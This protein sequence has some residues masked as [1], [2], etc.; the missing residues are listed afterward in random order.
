MEAYVNM[1]A[2]KYLRTKLL[3]FLVGLF[4][5]LS[6]APMFAFAE[7]SAVAGSATL[8][9]SR[10]ANADDSYISDVSAI[11]NFYPDATIENLVQAA[12]Q[13]GKLKALNLSDYGFPSS[14]VFNDNTEVANAADW[15]QSW[16]S[17]INGNASAEEFNTGNYSTIKLEDGKTYQIVLAGWPGPD[18]F[19]FFA[20]PEQGSA[21]AG[22]EPETED[23]GSK[24]SNSAAEENSNTNNEQQSAPSE[25]SNSEATAPSRAIN[26]NAL[27]DAIAASYAGTS[28]HAQ[29]MDLARACLL[30]ANKDGIVQAAADAVA[31]PTSGNLQR[32]ILA[33]TANGL[34]A[35]KLNSESGEIN[36][37]EALAQNADAFDATYISIPAFTLL[38]FESGPYQVPDTAP[39]GK[40]GLIQ[41]LLDSQNENGSY[42][43]GDVDT[44]AMVATAL[45]PYKSRADVATSLDKALSHLKN[46]Q[47]ATGGFGSSYGDV[48]TPNANSTASVVIALCALG[49]DPAKEWANSDGITPYEALL[50]FA[51]EALTAFTYDGTVDNDYA[52]EQGFCAM[53]A[54]KGFVKAGGAYNVYVDDVCVA[55]ASGDEQGE[56]SAGS[57]GTNYNT[58]T[59]AAPKTTA[60]TADTN[61]L[62]ALFMLCLLA[63]GATIVVGRKQ[64]ER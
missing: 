7:E 37:V 57:N 54:Y 35:T 51:N 46:E 27:F 30:T 14:L 4:L 59:S 31:S 53:V 58:G 56:G 12:I 11:Y 19:S 55:P 18:D 33:V 64:S 10:G 15:S 21:I 1:R 16:L 9:I 63:A 5:C 25:Q 45:A 2:A 41:L 50:Q 44:T 34:D 62:P 23:T 48:T 20:T 26:E 49:I 13:D 32:A 38:A 8:Q 6:M 61:A 22:T 24:D 47:L 17:Y 3:V 39:L 40:D 29:A 36:V 60:K 52:T 42:G 43:Y 28:F